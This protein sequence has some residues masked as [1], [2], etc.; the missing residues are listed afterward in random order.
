M[1]GSKMREWWR[2]CERRRQEFNV[3]LENEHRSVP[4][5]EQDSG[6]FGEL[7][8]FTHLQRV[9]KTISREGEG[10]CH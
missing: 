6:T 8:E 3:L 9:Y 5:S 7:A 10:W 2:W 1:I 4:Q